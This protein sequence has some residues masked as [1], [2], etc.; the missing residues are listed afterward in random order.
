[1]GKTRLA[2]LSRNYGYSWASSGLRNRMSTLLR[3]SLARNR[4][5]TQ[6]RTKKSTR[7]GNGVTSQHD[8][9]WVYRKKSM[10]RRKK[11]VWRSFVKKV[12]AVAE[13]DNGT[14][15]IVFNKFVQ[16]TNST[17]NRQAF[18]TVC[19][20]GM[21]SDSNT[22]YDDVYNMVSFE[23]AASPTDALGVTVWNS[24]KW[25]FQSGVLDLTLN[26]QSTYYNGSTYSL[27]GVMEIDVYEIMC[28]KDSGLYSNR[29]VSLDDVFSYYSGTSYT[30]IIGNAVSLLLSQLTMASRGATP[31]DFP[32]ALSHV[33]IKILNKKKYFVSAG[34]SITYQYRD[35]RRHVIKRSEALENAGFN[36]PGVTRCL[37]VIGKLAPGLTIGT[38]TGT[39]QEVINVGVTRKYMYKIE[40]VNEDRSAYVQQT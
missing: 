34:N 6:T 7:S 24:T 28:K 27:S 4:L 21:R 14:R 16:F 11:K 8:A 38:T 10:P 36:E 35:P 20:Y 19:L 29:F 22:L 15:T 2:R 37:L 9:R 23:N 39:Y 17:S 18:G 1:M 12:H 31:F 5:F 13:K 32:Q 3:Q 33:G 30:P 25:L 26:N 40:G